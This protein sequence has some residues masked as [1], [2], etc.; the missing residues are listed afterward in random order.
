MVSE[1]MLP[2]N[3]SVI[4]GAAAAVGHITQMNTPSRISFTEASEVSEMSH[5]TAPDR[6]IRMNCNQKCHLRGRKSCN[7][8]LQKVTNN[9]AKSTIGNMP[10][11]TG[12]HTSP[13]GA[14]TGT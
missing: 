11:S 6:H 2:P 14:S 7:C 3:F 4:T 13:T 12:S 10:V 1:A 5:T 9:K 8:I